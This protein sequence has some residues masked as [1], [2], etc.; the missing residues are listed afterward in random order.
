MQVAQ[1]WTWSCSVKQDLQPPH[2][3]TLDY[4][5]LLPPFSWRLEPIDNRQRWWKSS[6]NSPEIPGGSAPWHVWRWMGHDALSPAESRRPWSLIWR[7]LCGGLTFACCT[8]ANSLSHW[9][10]PEI[11]PRHR[12][13][14]LYRMLCSMYITQTK[15]YFK[16]IKSWLTIYIFVGWG[17]TFDCVM[18]L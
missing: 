16:G 9:T 6:M 4:L 1:V 7:S 10:S 17:L 15:L 2:P 8:R 13:H 3:K 5:Y 18:L 11:W 12:I 14:Q